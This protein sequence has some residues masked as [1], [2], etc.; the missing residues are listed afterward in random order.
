MEELDA[1]FKG[2]PHLTPNLRRAYKHAYMVY[3]DQDQED[4]D[5]DELSKIILSRP[6][7][8]YYMILHNRPTFG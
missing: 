2:N 5:F 1:F 8:D 7:E 3:E 4:V 6:E